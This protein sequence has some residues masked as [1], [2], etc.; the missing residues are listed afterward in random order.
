MRL[1]I[2]ESPYAGDIERNV[3]YLTRCIQDSL[4]HGEAP[5]ASHRMY[6]GAL[7]DSIENQRALGLTAGHAWYTVAHGCVVYRDLGI[8]KGMLRGIDI[9]LRHGLP[10]E[11][12]SL[13][14]CQ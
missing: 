8:S 7:D 1:V 14:K 9:A 13:E 10:V 3:A 12:R 5:F 4:S 2:L 11:Y 6:P